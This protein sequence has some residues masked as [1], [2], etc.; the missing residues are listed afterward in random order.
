MDGFGVDHVVVVED[1]GDHSRE[2]DEFE[3][4]WPSTAVRE[5]N[6]PTFSWEQLERQLVDLAATPAQ[7]TG[8]VVGLLASCKRHPRPRTLEKGEGPAMPAPRVSSRSGQA[9]T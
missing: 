7:A 2:I 4:R 6:L 9:S 3:T 5:E 1:N 8:I